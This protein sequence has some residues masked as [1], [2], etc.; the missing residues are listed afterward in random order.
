[1]Q[2]YF[3]RVKK[4]IFISLFMVDLYTII[5]DFFV[6]L[7]EYFCMFQYTPVVQNRS[8]FFYSVCVTLTCNPL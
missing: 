8:Y 2:H 1:M 6:T 5:I 7:I 4:L 3:M